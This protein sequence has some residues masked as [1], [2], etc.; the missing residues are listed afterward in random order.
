[1]TTETAPLPFSAQISKFIDSYISTQDLEKAAVEARYQPEMGRQL[2]KRKSVREEIER[3]MAAIEGEVHKQIAKK[4]IVTVDALDKNLMQVVRLTKTDIKE[5]PTLAA[6]KVKAIE[7]GYQRTGVLIDGNFIPDAGSEANK[8]DEAPRIFRAQEQ[9]I[10]THQITETRQVVTSRSV[11]ASAPPMRQSSPTI[12]A[13]PN[14][15]PWA[16][17]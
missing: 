2:W 3:R 17:F 5:S 16:K 15:D 14:S 1:M 4:R 7:L 10:I 13:D 12:D 8:P 11:E 6:S 9:S